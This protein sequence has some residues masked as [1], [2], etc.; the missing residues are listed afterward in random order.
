M[1]FRKPLSSHRSKLVAVVSTA[2]L[3]TACGGG[4]PLGPGT[5]VAIKTDFG[6]TSSPC[7]DGHPERGCIYLG[8]ILDHSG[9]F[10]ISGA[11]FNSS[12]RAYWHEVNA[13]GGIGGHHDVAVPDRLA[14]DNQYNPAA[15]TAAYTRIAD[16][17]LA[18][19]ASLGT[20]TTMDTL[21]RLIEDRTLVVP[22]SF[23]SGWSFPEIDHGVALEY[24]VSYCFEGMNAM[25]W[26]V[27]EPGSEPVEAVGIV[28]F[29]SD[30]GRDYGS[31]VKTAASAQG[32]EVRWEQPIVPIA[33]GGDPAQVEAVNRIVG[34]AQGGGS[35]AGD[36][37]D[38]VFMVIGPSELAAI[39]GGAVQRGFDGIFITGSPGWDAGLL[40]TAAAPALLSGRVFGTAGVAPW[41]SDTPGHRRAEA[42]LT[43]AGVDPHEYALSA[44]VSQ[45]RLQAVLEAAAAAGDLTR[46]G[47]LRASNELGVIDYEGMQPAADWSRP[48]T[49]PRHAFIG[50]FDAG[51]P[52][53]SVV[54]RDFF[55]GPTAASYAFDGP[56]T[57]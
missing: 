48:E 52:T 20:P 50:R 38:V 13:A 6:V 57:E 4:E 24:L 39:V 51:A 56:C 5:D 23:W 53:G 36:P 8:T 31:G 18:L 16:E 54:A 43:A 14:K 34:G 17:V 10:A 12:I 19:A 40:D 21:P 47:L 55:V 25:D 28:Y 27:E 46:D 22:N 9:P 11:V 42:A 3:A 33:A 30:Y 2:L 26:A 7:P 45:V 1:V 41:G 15:H 37:V 44:W 35:V 49:V 32:V 29:P